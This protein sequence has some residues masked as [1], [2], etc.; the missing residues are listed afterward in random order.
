MIRSVFGIVAASALALTAL[1]ALAQDAKESVV[2]VTV[3]GSPITNRDVAYTNEFLGPRLE[4][5][6]EQYRSRV[7]VDIL[8]DRKLYSALARTSNVETRAAYKERL[9]YLTEEAL[10]DIFIEK[11]M[12]SEIGDD[13]IKS[14]Y[15]QEIAKL[16]KT[17]E[18]HARHVLVKTE[19]Q[20]KE[21]TE[22]ARGGADFAELAKVHSTGPTG[23]G[24]GDLGYFTSDKMVPEF[25]AAA[26]G[27]E[28]GGISDPVK[29]Q[30]G[31]H[32]IKLEDKRSKAPPAYDLVKV[33]V[34]RMILGERVKDRSVALRKSAVIKYTEGH[35]PP[36]LPGQAPAAAN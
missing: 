26:G 28:I 4:Q 16:P 7:I 31:W 15:E 36:P 34:Q 27:L 14:R 25:S 20:A 13:A 1:P 18:M 2:I 11:V 5:V 24:G 12:N 17:D 9:A 8:I 23:P 3:D 30:F 19:E 22:K 10:R 32:V 6:P 35:E 33:A 21:I 29:T